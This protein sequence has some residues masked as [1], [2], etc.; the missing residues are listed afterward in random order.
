MCCF[1]RPVKLVSGTRIFARG[2]AD[3]TQALVYQMTVGLDG[4][5]AMIL[6]LPVPP[7]TP[8]DAVRFVDLS[9]YPRFFDD[10]ERGFPAPMSKS[11]PLTRAASRS[12]ERPRLRVHRVGDFDASFVPSPADLDRL[13]PRFRLPSTTF[14]AI[15]VYRDWGFA[16]FKLHEKRGWF[17]RVVRKPQTFHP[18]AFVFPRRDPKALFFPTVHV[19]DGAVH[20][21]AKFD[22]ALYAQ[23]DRELAPL[24]TW[25]RSDERAGAFMRA[26]D[27]A[28]IV[29]AEAPL[30]RVLYNGAGANRDVVLHADE[31]HARVVAG[32]RFCLRWRLTWNDEAIERFGMFPEHPSWARDMPAPQRRLGSAIAGELERLVAEH[33]DAWELRPYAAELPVWYPGSEAIPLPKGWAIQPPRDGCRVTF[34]IDENLL[35]PYALVLELAFSKPPPRERMAA[36]A[37]SLRGALSRAHTVAAVG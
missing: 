25:Q 36:I 34:P 7:G 22:H 13:D 16:V 11:N 3:G 32:D 14:E 6:P 33:A 10:A 19:H 28:G 12:P 15:P 2:L 31:L 17:G 26:A 8:E 4:D 37:E 35:N 29:D 30:Y 24:C 21:E 27:T 9:G 18:M 5:L 1:S 23:L 20:S